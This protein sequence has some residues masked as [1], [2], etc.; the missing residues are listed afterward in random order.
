MN[1]IDIVNVK[2]FDTKKEVSDFFKNQNKKDLA[3]GI[4]YRTQL[5]Y[6]YAEF[7]VSGARRIF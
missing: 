6:N 5:I 1:R 2:F 7:Y 4:A 3:Y